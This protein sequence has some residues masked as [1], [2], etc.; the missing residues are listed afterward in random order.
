MSQQICKKQ[1]SVKTRIENKISLEQLTHLPTFAQYL[2]QHRLHD[3]VDL[4]LR[5]SEEIDLPMMQFLKALTQ[6]Q[7]EELALNG[8]IEFLSYLAEN[9]ARLQIEHSIRQWKDNQLPILRKEEIV[10]DDITMLNYLRKKAFLHFIPDYCDATDQM[11]ELID[12]I[13]LFLTCSETAL[14]NTY[15][16]LLKTRISDDSLLIEKVNDT[17]PGAVYVFDVQQFKGVYSNHKLGSIF[18]YPQNELIQLAEPSIGDL[19]HPDDQAGMMEHIQRLKSAKDGEIRIFKYRI[20]DRHGNYRWLANHESIFKRDEQGEV[21]HTIGITLDID[22]EERTALALRENENLR[23]QAESITHIGHYTWDVATNEL[24]WSDELY[25]I[26]G[27]TPEKETIDFSVIERFNHPEDMS[28]IREETQRAVANKTSF[29]FHYRIITRDGIEKTLHALGNVL[30]DQFGEPKQVLGT[31]QDVTEKQN[32]IRKLSH[33]ESI[34]KQAEELANMG[35]WSLDLSTNKLQ[36]TDQ[37]YRI[38]GMQPQSGE[39]T[40]D[41]FLSFVHPEDRQYVANGI[42]DMAQENILDYTF[43]IITADGKTKILR[44]VAQVQKDQNGKPI[45]V[46]GTERDVTEKQ[47]LITS[48]R[49]SEKLYKQA[50]ALAHV[51][52]WSWDI[53]SNQIE[54][55]DELY[56]IYGL[57]PQSQI[58]AFDDYVAYIHPDDRDDVRS[59]I[60]HALESKEPWSFTHKVVRQ[61]GEVRIVYATGEV[62]ADEKGKP[63]MMVG[64][65]QDVTERQTLIDR[66]Q[67]SERLF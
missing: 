56:R 65:A 31:V 62:L 17:I 6:E 24:K 57:E 35:N 28:I 61:S 4:Q 44:S 33:N 1:F 64:T 19:I 53:I 9:K 47:N 2:L 58:L 52:N 30:F 43:R 25:R 14:T 16:N 10:A 36:W 8:A 55:S 7:L 20:K 11:I 39:M 66:L 67:E 5:L 18:G 59:Q 22:K 54:W 41:R 27:F 29:D 42:E 60:A 51:G 50:Q 3:F 40:I 23:K 37:L 32:L 49:K 63:Y 26:Y 21:L 38:Y 48:L 34:Y 46:V 45:M 15:I 13:D 12:E